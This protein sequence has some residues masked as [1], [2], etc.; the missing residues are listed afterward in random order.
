M[1]GLLGPQVD[2]EALGWK[3]EELGKPKKRKF[4]WPVASVRAP[5]PQERQLLYVESQQEYK[6]FVRFQA[7]IV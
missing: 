3:E 5:T 6:C 4:G 7:A 1:C 2:D